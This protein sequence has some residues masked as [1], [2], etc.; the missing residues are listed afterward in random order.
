MR[1]NILYTAIGAAAIFNTVSAQINQPNII[2]LTAD[3]LGWNDISSLAATMQFGSKNHQTPNINKLAAEGM[4]FTNAYSQ[5]NSA[6]TRVALLTGQYAN[7]THVYNVGGLDRYSKEN[8]NGIRK[9][10]ALII[11]AE[12]KKES[13]QQGTLTF[14]QLLNEAGYETYI[15]GKVHGFTLN[16]TNT[17]GFTHNFECRKTVKGGGNKMSNYFA[18]QQDNGKWIFDKPK[19]DKY[20]MPYTKEYIEMNLMPFANG[21]DPMTLIG[22]KKHFTDAL[23]D[24][25]IEQI[26]KADTEKP[27]C[28]WVAFHAIHSAVVSRDDLYDK[29][30]NRSHLDER[31]SDYKYAA[32]TEQL[33]QT[34]GRILMAIDDPN[35]DGDTSDSMRENT[36][37][38][39]MSDNGGIANANHSNAPLL[40]SK[41]TLYEG[42]IRIPMIVRY[43]AMVQPSSVSDESVHVID[44]L[45]TFAE[46]AGTKNNYKKHILDG[47]SL[48]SIMAGKKKNLKRKALYW[49]F[50]GYM[51]ERGVPASV[52]NKQINGKRYK[53]RYCYEYGTHELYNLSDDIGE[54]RNLLDTKS[55]SMIKVADELLSDLREW[56]RKTKP[57]PMYYVSNGQK[58]ELP[59]KVRL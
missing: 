44:Y 24:M 34:V 20:A 55:A 27:F 22:S 53:Y 19:Y 30:R 49:H 42:G 59:K 38:I 45:P 35:N 17:Y 47:E 4:V 50:P 39:F 10:D 54:S 56:I 9:E 57:L 12:Q 21:N 46:L 43:P 2:L 25:V 26:S 18:F 28:M 41:G 29:Y 23:G 31:H 15:F 13:L 3:D 58:V 8:Q 7:R 11:P 1:N 52:I 33:D 51:D 32:L 36:V 6:P 40:E 37:I 14:A 5:Q 16:D 48:V